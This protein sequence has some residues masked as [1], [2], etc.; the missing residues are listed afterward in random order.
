[1]RGLRCLVGAA[2]RDAEPGPQ[3]VM[4]RSASDGS[5]VQTGKP[6][7]RDERRLDGENLVAGAAHTFQ[8]DHWIVPVYSQLLC[9]FAACPPPFE[10][11]PGPVG[12]GVMVRPVG[13]TQVLCDFPASDDETAA[14]LARVHPALDHEL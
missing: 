2:E 14:A 4:Q 13:R 3:F 11:G 5:V 1:M 6:F 8:V 10:R 7:G 12:Q 9:Q